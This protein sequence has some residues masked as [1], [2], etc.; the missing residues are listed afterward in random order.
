LN[1][2]IIITT[3]NEKSNA[4][5]AFEQLKDWHILIVGD[6]KSIFIADSDNL[7]FLSVDKQKDLDFSFVEKCPYNHYSRKNIGY[8]YAMSLGAEVIYDTDDDNH[9]LFDWSLPT[10]SCRMSYT[11][12]NKFL[13][14]YKYFT[15]Q[16]VWPRGFPLD[17][18]LRFSKGQEKEASLKEIGV[19][20]GLVDKDPDVDAIY[21][22][23]L[24]K[25]ILFQNLPPVYIEK[26]TYCPFNSQ[27]TFWSPKAFPLLYLPATVDFRF[28]D[29]LRGYIAQRILWKS[30]L[31]LG[32]T[33]ATVV[34][35]RNVH[36]LMKDF[37]DEVFSYQ[38]IKNIIH[39]LDKLKFSGNM[40]QDL[41]AAYIKLNQNGFIENAELEI[42]KAWQ[43]DLKRIVHG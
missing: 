14:I 16:H 41:Y 22:L 31:H 12:G 2:Y 28:T 38:K 11:N 42:L 33:H 3:I 39:V 35:E 4:I 27:N 43:K 13:N 9:P 30:D 8:L 36:D 40:R 7:T 29:I 32:F 6:Q 1:K 17:E 19:W 37:N 18:I 20:Q 5:F 24:N 21:R 15:V 34:Q 26:G 10:F 23:V 25:P